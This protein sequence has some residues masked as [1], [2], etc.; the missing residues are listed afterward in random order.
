MKNMNCKSTSR[1]QFVRTALA[2]GVGGYLASAFGCSR[3]ASVVVYC[4]LDS[5]YSDP[6]LQDL[7]REL[8]ITILPKFDVESTKT[9][10]L[11]NA[12]L[13]ET[14]RT[15]CDLFWNNEILNT[16]RLAE[17]GL[18][19]P[20][21]AQLTTGIPSAF[22]DADNLWCGFAARARVLLVNTEQLKGQAEPT[23]IRDL[24]SAAFQGKCSIAKPLFGT[25]ATHAA[26]CVA[27]WGSETAKEFF[28]NLKQNKIQIAAGNKAVAQDVA[29]GAATIGLTDT[30]DALWAV[31]QG[32][33]VKIIYPDQ[34]E[35]E[36]GV[37]LL[38][39][40]LAL[41]K[42]GPH[43]EAAR[44]VANR[45]V[46]PEVE[47]RL[48]EGPSGQFPLHGQT[49]AELQT[50]ALSSLNTMQ[51]DWSRAAAAWNEARSFLEKEFLPPG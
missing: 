14:G 36:L 46:S 16:V 19:A 50:P 20:L 5:E 18:L 45:I 10:G 6:I 2:T 51:V 13:A 39:N 47:K 44:K 49:K 38:P 11:V 48:A 27:M 30:D 25:T 42:D 8:G 22:K 21:P 40:T 29:A 35:S 4:A 12:I 3:Q 26:V 28:R 33:P 41:L 32:A 37:L 34:A 15:R 24:A 9:V 7:A 1:R 43:R 17:R 31:R 23:S